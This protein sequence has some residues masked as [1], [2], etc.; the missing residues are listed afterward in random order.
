MV[1]YIV[2]IYKYLYTNG[3]IVGP[4]YSLI[5]EARKSQQKYVYIFQ[6]S[7]ALLTP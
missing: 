1:S 7:S 4:N 3:G 2:F 5:K 6:L